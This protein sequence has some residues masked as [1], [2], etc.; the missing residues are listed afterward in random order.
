MDNGAIAIREALPTFGGAEIERAMQ[1]GDLAKMTDEER[2][3]PP[4]E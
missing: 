2:A 3:V 4:Y 1:F